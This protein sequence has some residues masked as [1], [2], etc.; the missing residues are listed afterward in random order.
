MTFSKINTTT[1]L[2]NLGFETLNPMQEAMLSASSKN[3]NILLLAPTG[4]GKT[5]AY[6]AS[7]LSKLEE[8]PGVQ[9]LILAPTRELVLQIENVLK[10][11]KLP[12]KVNACYGG[13]Q[14]SIERQNFKSPPTILIGTPGRIEDHI[15]RGTFNPETIARIVFDE[16]DKA[17]EFGFSKQMAAILKEIPN[18]IG[19]LLVSATQAIEIPEYLELKEIHTVDFSEEEKGAIESQ[20]ITTLIDEKTAGLLLLLQSFEKNKNAIVFSNHREACDRICDYLDEHAVVYS[21]FH[22]GLEQP[23]RELELLKFRNGSSRIL[24]ATD[25]AARGIDIPELDA[26]IHYQMPKTE[27]TFVHRNGR[28]ARM[29]SSGRSILIRT[30][31]DEL[32]SYIKET[33]ALI[34]L[35]TYDAIEDPEWITFYV[36]KGKKDK[37]NKMDLV[38]FFLQFDFVSKTD[39]GLIEVKDFSAYIAIKRN[40]S[41]RLLAASRNL[42]IKNKKAKIAFAK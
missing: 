20:Q 23:Q 6:L 41:K 26:V 24:I 7:I 42:K 37:V 34:N 13:H 19:K 10:L 14:F 11:M 1:L 32:P 2:K 30:Q 15:R 25:I 4:S 27:S 5:L 17:L 38:G 21:I 28:T 29:K 8:K 3:Q 36:G 35:E 16:F 12:C 9:V 31:N 18:C 22:G 40:K 33:P 39:L